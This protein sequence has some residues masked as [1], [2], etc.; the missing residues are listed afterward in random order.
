M[1]YSAVTKGYILYDLTNHVFFINRD[2]TFREGV[3]PFKHKGAG[4]QP[5]FQT[6]EEDHS[7]IFDTPQDNHMLPRDIST[8]DGDPLPNTE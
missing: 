7:T 5:L 8:Q 6:S 4:P 3:F 2:V 1:G